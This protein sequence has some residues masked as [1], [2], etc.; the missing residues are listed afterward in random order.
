MMLS[1]DRK[2]NGLVARRVFKV[3]QQAP[4]RGRLRFKM[5]CNAASWCGTYQEE[6]GTMS[7]QL[8][9]VSEPTWSALTLRQYPP[10]TAILLTRPF[11]PP[12]VASSWRD[13][14]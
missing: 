5:G 4:G 6:R 14:G 11:P 2:R 7:T 12:S 3:D 9:I 1:R 13:P 8:V 10:P